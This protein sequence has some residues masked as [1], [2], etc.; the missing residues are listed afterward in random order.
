[1]DYIDN[2]DEAYSWSDL[3]V[4][5]GGASTISE[6][7]I[8]KKPAFIFPY[9]H[10][11]QHQKYNAINL[12]DESDFAVEFVEIDDSQELKCEKLQKFIKNVFESNPID[13]SLVKSLDPRDKILEEVGVIL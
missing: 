6:L 11:D 10:S 5:R 2:I 3:I 4:S 12:R 13:Y 7:K 1:M 8:V 9:P